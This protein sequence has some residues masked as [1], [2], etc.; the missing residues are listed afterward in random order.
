MKYLNLSV[1][2]AFA[3][4]LVPNEDE[5]GFFARSWCNREFQEMSLDPR[6]AQCSVSFNRLKGTLRGMHYQTAP[7]CEAKLVRCTAG[8]I[9]DVVLDLRPDSPSFLKSEGVELTSA[10]HRMLYVPHGCAHGFLSLAEN[11]E[12]FYQISEFYSP[13]NAR[14]VRW[15]D[16]LFAI[17]W[18]AS[19]DTMSPKDRS[20]ADSR[21]GDFEPNR[22]LLRRK[23]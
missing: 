4:D 13:E 22:G 14:G 18:P 23:V 15:D 8:A 12:V 17:K 19:P 5:R 21:P 9:F 3:V 16:P 11:S 7:F 6:M 1:V 2:G 10:N 20:Y